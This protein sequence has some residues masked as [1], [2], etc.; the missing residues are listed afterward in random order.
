MKRNQLFWGFAL[1]LIGVL[2]LANAMGIKLP[3]GMSLTE[4]FWPLLLIFGGLWVL[5]GVFLRGSIEIE[6]ASVD[7]QGASSA[8]LK[9]SHGA[10]DLKIHSGANAGELAHGSFTGGLQQKAKHNSWIKSFHCHL[11][12]L[13]SDRSRACI[14]GH[15][16]GVGG[17]FIIGRLIKTTVTREAGLIDL[18]VCR[19]DGSADSSR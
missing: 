6:N 18:Q 5:V 19:A 1:L 17:S 8:N 16:Y 13:H 11:L 7:L 4:L 14:N 10:G 2:M 15:V 12:L 9:I 3:N